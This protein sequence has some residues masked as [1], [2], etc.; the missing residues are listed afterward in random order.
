M[1]T[2][3]GDWLRAQDDATLAALVRLRPDLTVPPPAD[4]TVLATRAGVRTSVH[5]ACDDLDTPTLA[6]MEPLGVA[7][8]D[9]APVT[10]A[11][12]ARLLGPDVPLDALDAALTTL[13]ARALIWEADAP[14][15]G[16]A[17]ADD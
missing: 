8:A 17:A 15:T 6:V 5:R 13:R 2:P 14:A 3:L 16:A 11:E 1:S 12:V 4:L 7:D 9:R 10:R